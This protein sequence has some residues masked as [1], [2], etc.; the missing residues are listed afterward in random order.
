MSALQP[1]AQLRG[2]TELAYTVFAKDLKALPDDKLNAGCGESGRAP[3]HIAAECGLVNQRVAGYL[4]GE[5][6]PRPSPE[7]REALLC[8][9]DTREKALAFLE[10]GT[11]TLLKALEELDENTL[12]DVD[13]KFFEGM[14][15]SRFSV[16]QL[17]A[18][19]MMYHDGQLNYIQTLY[20]DKQMHWRD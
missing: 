15:M 10:E 7:E 14:P 19:H 4:R 2:F 6:L 17:P 9:F 8:S 3:L 13:E 12:G 5:E 1:I 11:Q 20:G 16:A 18:V